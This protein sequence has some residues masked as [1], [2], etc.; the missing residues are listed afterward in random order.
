M[1]IHYA[2]MC[3]I[4]SAELT[5]KGQ[6]G[7]QERQHPAW[8]WHEP[9]AAPLGL[10]IGQQ[11]DEPGPLVA[12]RDVEALKGRLPRAGHGRVR[13]L[14]TVVGSEQERHLI[15][16]PEPVEVLQEGHQPRVAVTQRV[17][18]DAAARTAG[19]MSRVTDDTGPPRQETK[20]AEE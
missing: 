6:S 2:V 4:G 5:G 13:S 10:A 11:V 12:K 18:S 14:E 19:V 9:P 17:P 16:D 3:S 1:T 8:L 7:R 15:G 20:S